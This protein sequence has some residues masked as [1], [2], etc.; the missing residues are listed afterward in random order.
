M[1]ELKII[2]TINF[3]GTAGYGKKKSIYFLVEA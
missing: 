2:S 3:S 1:E